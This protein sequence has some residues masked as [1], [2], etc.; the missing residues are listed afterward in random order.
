MELRPPNGGGARPEDQTRVDSRRPSLEELE[1]RRHEELLRR[2]Q[3]QIVERARAQAEARARAVLKQ[4]V[5]RPR[6]WIKAA[7][8]DA[9]PTDDRPPPPVLPFRPYRPF[10]LNSLLVTTAQ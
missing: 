5:T 3:E 8:G 10:D 7:F 1:R 6:A 4:N 2:E 9:K